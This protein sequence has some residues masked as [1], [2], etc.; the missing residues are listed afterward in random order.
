MILHIAFSFASGFFVEAL[1]A[2]GVIFI[3]ER[4]AWLSALL[5]SLWGA[6][7]LVGVNE[8]F[9][10][11]W[12]AIAWCLGLGAGALVAVKYRARR[13]RSETARGK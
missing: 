2:L 13:E 3:A 7:I 6:A 5:S 8:A 9:R 12:A 10:S 1:Y 4:R 11:T